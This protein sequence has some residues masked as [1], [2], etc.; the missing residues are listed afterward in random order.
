MAVNIETLNRMSQAHGGDA[1]QIKQLY[2]RYQRAP[3]SI[4][5][6]WRTWFQALDRQGDASQTTASPQPASTPRPKP[7][8]TPAAI[9]S[10][11]ISGS[12][13][14]T[15]R[16]AMQEKQGAVLRLINA[17][18]TRGHQVADIEPLGLR[19]QTY[20][21]DLDPT[22]H[23]LLDADM[24]VV[25]NTGSLF[26]PDQMPLR[27][28]IDL[29]QK[30]YCGPVGSEIMHINSTH[31]KR[32]LQER[33]EHGMLRMGI[34]TEQKRHI[35]DRLSAAEGLERYLHT[36]YVG[37]KRFSLEGGESLIPCLDELV[38]RAGANGIREAVIGMAHRGR[39]NVLVNIMGKSPS[40]LFEEFEGK[41]KAAEND[42]HKWSSGDVKYHM[43]FSSDVMTPGGRL[44][45]A[46]AFN[47]SHLEIVNPVVEGSVRARQKRRSDPNGDQVLPILI[48]GDAAFA[49][50][51]VI[52]ECFNMSQAQGYATGGTVHIIVNNQIG[53]TTSDP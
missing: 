35:F 20:I 48:H 12:E 3:G 5:A 40:I 33:L 15:T 16:T 29:L 37:Q 25:F 21:A 49:G 30:V 47:P 27:D 4:P 26:A 43:G 28:I 38:Q 52:M 8:D 11:Q 7:A 24:D 53:F 45:L 13:A 46:L 41:V 9:A 6:E 34:D 42:T 10:Q 17:H 23:G 32:W 22:F 19:E 18:R 14:P 39:L 44:H 50:Q 2:E 36:K 31:E 51:G 1:A